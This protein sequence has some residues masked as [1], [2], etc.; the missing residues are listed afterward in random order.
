MQNVWHWIDTAILLVDLLRLGTYSGYKQ[1]VLLALTSFRSFRV[2][3]RQPTIRN[4]M[5]ALLK[6]MGPIA[7]VF[8]LGAHKEGLCLYMCIYKVTRYIK[9]QAQPM[10]GDQVSCWR[11][12]EVKVTGSEP[13]S[14]CFKA[15]WV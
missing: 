12:V 13:K 1:R 2:M 10:A 8:L 6:T 14:K 7:T 4:L 11:G 5:T 15:I 9:K 3:V